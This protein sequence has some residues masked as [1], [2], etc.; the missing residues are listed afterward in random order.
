MSP[1]TRPRFCV[2][3]LLFGSNPAALNPLG[4]SILN[5]GGE[6]TLRYPAGDRPAAGRHRRRRRTTIC[7]DPPSY[8][9]LRRQLRSVSRPRWPEATR[10]FING[11]GGSSE[12]SWLAGSVQ[13]CSAGPANYRSSP[14]EGGAPWEHTNASEKQ[15]TGS[16]G[17][18]LT[19]APEILSVLRTRAGGGGWW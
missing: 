1:H 10:R 3:F 11:G 17:S 7:G 9:Q 14:G 12:Q 16:G 19:T 8:L 4:C 15:R 18:A 2:S 5:H 13:R 6:E